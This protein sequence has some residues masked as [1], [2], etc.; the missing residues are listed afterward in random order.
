MVLT[1]TAILLQDDQF[2]TGSG[3]AYVDGVIIPLAQA[4]NANSLVYIDATGM[5][6]DLGFPIRTL[7]V[8]F[9]ISNND[10]IFTNGFE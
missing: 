3:N 1:G 10:V 5:L 8:A 9:N 4:V 7:I 6:P 2:V